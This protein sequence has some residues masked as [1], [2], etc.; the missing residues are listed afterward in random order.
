MNKPNTLIIIIVAIVALLIGFFV[1]AS[2]QFFKVKTPPQQTASTFKLSSTVRILASKAIGKVT[3]IQGRDLTMTL[4]GKTVS[5]SVLQD[6]TIYLMSPKA[7]KSDFNIIKVGDTVSISVQI[8]NRGE[9]QGTS[10]MVYPSGIPTT[11]KK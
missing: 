6:A 11:T 4:S 1:G 10:V 2:Y 9:A 3:G 8:S 7:T 5:I